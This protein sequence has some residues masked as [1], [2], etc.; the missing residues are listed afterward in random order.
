V[1]L[2][3]VSIQRPVLTIVLNLALVLFGLIGLNLLGVR[4]YPAID[5]PIVSVN[6][7]YSGANADVIESQITEPLE[8]A[9]NSVP[10]VKAISSTSRDGRSSISIE[11]ELGI[12]MEA[13]ANDVRDKVSRAQRNLPPDAD[14]PSISK[15]DADATPIIL[16][17]ILS[18]TRSAVELSA[19]A[20][21]LIKER[22]QTIPGLSEARLQGEKKYAIRL[23]LDPYKMAA[24]G[25]AAQDVKAALDKENV[26]LPSGSVEG[27]QVELTVRTVSRLRTPE[28]FNTLILKETGGQAVRLG[29]IG[30][31][32][33]GAENARTAMK[34]NGFP[35]VGV[36]LIPQPGANH[37]AIAGEFYHRLEALKKD[38]PKD[39]KLSIG[40]DTTRFIVRS[41]EEVA[42]TL[43]IALILVILIIFIFFRNWRTTLIPILAIPVSLLSAFFIMYLSGFSLNI[44]TL[45]AIVLSTGLVVDDAIVVLENIY[46][47]VEKGMDP[48]EAGH[49]GSD[50]IFFAIV[51]TTLTLAAVFLPI[52]FLQGTTGRLFREFGVVVAGAVL[53][54]AFVSLT[55]T[56]MLCTRLLKKDQGA[57]AFYRRTEP[58]FEGM[59]GRYRHSLEAF[60]RKRWLVFPIMGASFAL[61]AVLFRTLPSEIAPLEDKG[62]L[63]VSV[64]AQE[65]AT[66]DFMDAYMD[67]LVPFVDA[68]VPEAAAL[69]SQTSPGGGSGGINRGSIQVILKDVKQRKRSQAQI[70]A[71]L[72][73]KLKKFTDV[74]VSVTQ[75]QTIGGRRGGDPVQF[76]I[77]TPDF[78]KLRDKLPKFL[79]RAAREPALQNVDVNLKFT[80]P[81]LTLNID[82][83]KAR[84]LGVSALDISQC[85]QF[86]LS[87]SRFGYF[88]MNGKQYSIIGQLD[89][90][91]RD[92]PLDLKS[93]YVR[94][95][96]GNLIQ[97]DNLVQLT[98]KSTPPQ[99]F[100]YNRF[101]SATVTAALAE[102]HTISDGIQAMEA[103]ARDALDETFTTA[104]SGSARDFVESSS[105]LIY[106]FLFALILIYMVLAAQFESF[107]DPFIVMFT[108]PLA[109][110]GA[111]LS[112]WYFRQT[113]N[114]FSQIGIIMLIGLVTKNGILIVEF[115][116]HKIQEG[117]PLGEAIVEGAVSRFRPILM[118]SFATALGALPIA[119]ALGAGAKSRVSMGIA[120]IGGLMFSLVLTLFVIP[121]MCGYLGKAKRLPGIRADAT[122]PASAAPRVEAPV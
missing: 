29:D 30:K 71:A 38:L 35:A 89:R 82:R 20:N 58:F 108:V 85:L 62:R 64:T 118:T 95:Q 41:L 99:L 37:I 87:E 56:P 26:E 53:V 91:D 81:E 59:T 119:L 72:T 106:A 52:I 49:Q 102:G 60:L 15:A 111:L 1:R 51:S 100:R 42:E 34:N 11:F 8:E 112:L 27:S 4:D 77:Q 122:L 98:E 79:E 88:V 65:G 92:S 80:K 90:A 116:N 67:R 47:K 16:L 96:D 94:G 3:S 25:V 2:S 14:N 24:R 63:N 75:E 115:V 31:A 105:T 18:D 120:V 46:T 10:G 121:A 40:L 76:I 5:P 97:L 28:E 45:L 66:F 57:G 44:L 55:L 13:A 103:A 74:R 43:I 19:L 104:L 70:A 50:E 69:I 48:D 6:T 12:D 32:E 22:L 78:A 23:W 113:L 33:L 21:D 101:S 61:V 93:I 83:N 84:A 73:R 54:S 9:V 36:Q 7:S 107:R 114:I 17:S 117:I 86:G 68:E 110:A 39:V 109:F